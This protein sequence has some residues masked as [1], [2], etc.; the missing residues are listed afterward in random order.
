MKW[1]ICPCKPLEGQIEAVLLWVR[2]FINVSA[3]GATLDIC[4]PLQRTDIEMSPP[5]LGLG[6]TAN[7][8]DP[9]SN[10]VIVC[11]HCTVRSSKVGGLGAEFWILSCNCAL[12]SNDLNYPHA[13]NNKNKHDAVHAIY[14][15]GR[16][17]MKF[18]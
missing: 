14:H 11:M 13:I 8:H 12:C 17:E 2:R 15:G 5:R 10:Y 16:K 9:R 4:S 7:N 1:F 6:T 3:V 18:E